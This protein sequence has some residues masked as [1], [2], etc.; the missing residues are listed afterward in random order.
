MYQHTDTCT[1]TDATCINEGKR[2]TGGTYSGFHPH[3]NADLLVSRVDDASADNVCLNRVDVWKDAQ[4]R[5]NELKKQRGPRKQ[6]IRFSLFYHIRN[7]LTRFIT[8]LKRQANGNS[9]RE[10][11]GFI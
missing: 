6:N 4:A 5:S 3:E 10:S 9:H 11:Y 8:K 2:G 7:Q 1:N